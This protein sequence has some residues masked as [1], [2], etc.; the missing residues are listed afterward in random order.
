MRSGRRAL[1][2]LLGP[3]VAISGLAC[4]S[5]RHRGAAGAAPDGGSD[6][7]STR[8]MLS[9]S[10]LHERYVYVRTSGT[11][12]YL[13]TMGAHCRGLPNALGVTITGSGSRVCSDTTSVVTYVDSGFARTCPIVH[14]E[15]VA[16]REEAE[17]LVRERSTSGREERP[18]G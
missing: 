14:V 3:I 4:A 5:Q 1:V 13:L 16:D 15:S 6:C 9:A 18:P 11:G 7:F 17:R 10:P 8:R 12:H 2:W